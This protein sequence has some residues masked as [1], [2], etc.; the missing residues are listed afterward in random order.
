MEKLKSIVKLAERQKKAT[1]I[2]IPNNIKSLVK[3][4]R[5]QAWGA[6]LMVAMVIFSFGILVFFLYSINTPTEAEENIGT[7]SYEGKI[8]AESILSEGYPQD[9]TSENVVTMG[10]LSQGKINETKVERFYALTQTQ[11]DYA[12]TKIIFNTRYDY[13]FFLDRNMVIASGEIEGIGKPGTV[14]EN[15]NALN[16]IKITKFTIYQDKPTTAYLYIWEE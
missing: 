14:K 1:R 4:K 11:E 5:S 13:Y 8:I 12:K 10:I 9:W 15:I 3:Y 7:L 16:L 2:C 6:D